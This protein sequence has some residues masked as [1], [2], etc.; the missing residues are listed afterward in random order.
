MADRTVGRAGGQTGRLTTGLL[1]ILILSL[2]SALASQVPDSARADTTRRPA[3]SDTSRR[4]Q[5]DTSDPTAI[6]LQSQED[7]KVVLRSFPRTGSEQLLPVSGRIVL[8]RDSIEYRNAETVSDILATLDGVYVWR[9]GWVGRAEIPDYQ[10][11]GS[12][13]VEYLLDGVPF[14]AMGSDSVTVDPSL[15][16]LSL[17][18]RMEIERLPGLLRV[19]IMLRN[20]ELLAPRTR[21][22][23]ARG[24][25]EQARYEGGFE[26]RFRKG[27]GVALAAEFLTTPSASRSFQHSTGWLQMDYVPSAKFGVQGRYLL[28]ST[29]REAELDKTTSDTLTRAVNGNRNEFAMRLFLRDREDGLGRRLDVIA[30]RGATSFD[31]LSADRWQGGVLASQRGEA[32]SLGLSAFYGTRWTRLDTRL[33]AGWTPTPV[34][35]LA[36]EVAYQT[37]DQERTAGWVM[38]RAGVRLPL[39]TD[40]TGAWRIG[41]VV[42]QP[43]VGSDSAQGISDREAFLSWQRPRLG[44]RVGYT[45]LSEF[46]PAAY[47]QFATVDSIGPNP[48]TEWVLAGAR[49]AIRPWFSIAGWYREPLGTLGPEGAPPGLGFVEAAIRSK[50]LRTFPSGIFDLKL[51]VS[52]ESWGTGSLGRGPT[53]A[54]VTLDGATFLRAQLQMQFSGFIFY[55]DRF[56]LTNSKKAYVP[57]LPIPGNA[58]TFGVRWTF[59]N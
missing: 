23:I 4:A 17:I 53:G 44:L 54:P 5:A 49:L 34:V 29:D 3:P 31:S 40:L 10:G 48:P 6:L 18:D 39:G 38:G 46:R 41:N 28:H 45:R 32:Y 13:S 52:M 33:T 12:T 27:L 59:L 55:L 58:Q 26:K 7:S 15:M 1:L 37:F 22:G 24:Q 35:T 42:A 30:S 19:N 8:P 36:A 43:T 25:F 50:F 14:V 2:P 9:G 47:W 56:N 11:R 57:G 16:P 51:A 21:V 20:H